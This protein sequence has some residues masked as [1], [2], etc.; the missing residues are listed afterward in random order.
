[1]IIVADANIVDVAENYQQHGELRLLNGRAIAPGDVADADALLVRSITPVNAALLEKSRVRFVATATS[2]TNHLDLDYLKARQ[3]QVCDAAGSNANAVVEY[4]LCAL[5]ELPQEGA[6]VALGLGPVGIVGYGHVGKRL[7]E[8]LRA[9]GIATRLCDPFVAADYPGLSFCSLEE[10]MACP[11]VSLHTPLTH[12][13]PYPTLH[14]LDERMLSRLPESAVLIN[15]AR[16]ELIDT[17][18]LTTFLRQRPD[19]QS[20]VDC[21]EG[22]PLI[23]TALLN[24][25]RLGSPHIAGYSQQ[26][27]RSASQ[28]NYR[29]FLEFFRL[30]DARYRQPVEAGR[31]V[32]RVPT[33]TRTDSLQQL[34][35][36]LR[37]V[38]AV[39]E[40]DTRLRGAGEG[41][42]AALFD[43]IRRDLGSRQEFSAYT[44]DL[45]GWAEAQRSQ[46]ILG[47]LRALGFSLSC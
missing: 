22:E 23:S 42:N 18:V 27:K 21:W 5:A 31:L 28:A 20:I 24:L 11:I 36:I 34:A 25:V 40:I 33:P 7:H 37:Q 30:H 14:M 17:A 19:V 47:H 32:L 39:R 45:S 15:A 44:L 10:I 6:K 3:I 13:G 12:E 2:G 43:G 41:A 38:F 46:A 29:S 8:Q 1:M 4:V 35:T 16:G 9:L 26:A